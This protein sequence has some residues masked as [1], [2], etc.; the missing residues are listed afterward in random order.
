MKSM[1]TVIKEQIQSFYLIRRLSMFEMRSA[2]NNNYLGILWEIINPGIQIMI[3]WFVFGF[4]IRRGENVQPFDIPF[5]FWMLSGIM[6]WF[7]INPAVLESSKS[8]YTR[9][10]FISKMSFPMSVIPS[11]V[12]FAKFYQHLMLTGIILIIFQ[13]TDYKISPYIIQLPYFM[14]SLLVLLL[15]LA[16]VTSTLSTI[17]RDVQMVIQSIMR[18]MLYLTP[19]LWPPYRFDG[20]YEWI[21]TV[22]QINPFYYIVEGYRAAILGT[23]WYFV[24]HWR[25]TLYFWAVVIV[26]LAI[27]SALHVKF[28]RHFVD[29]L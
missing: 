29:Y 24:D 26:I 23:E 15:A 11:Y 21:Q 6:V 8:I 4:G 9:I 3:Y 17:V 27:G 18:V 12:I 10:N 5:I 16:L 22:M 2:N 7:F 13:F 25:Y 19:L 14:F 1:F 20:K 28:R